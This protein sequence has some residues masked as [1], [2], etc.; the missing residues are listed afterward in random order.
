M[1]VDIPCITVHAHRFPTKSYTKGW[2]L[3]RMVKRCFAVAGCFD[4]GLLATSCQGLVFSKS[5]RLGA[6]VA[7]LSAIF[8]KILQHVLT[9]QSQ[10][11]RALGNRRL[12][13]DFDLLSDYRH[14][15]LDPKGQF[16]KTW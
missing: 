2:A 1:V 9:S 15:S 12:R 7:Q 11:P 6:V 4:Y 10:I 14:N 8:R 3:L 13:I 5:F 16:S